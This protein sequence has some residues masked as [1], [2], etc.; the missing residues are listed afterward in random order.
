MGKVRQGDQKARPHARLGDLAGQFGAY[1]AF[2]LGVQ[3]FQAQQAGVM[4]RYGGPF[5]VNF[6][7]Q[8]FGQQVG[9]LCLALAFLLA[10]VG[11]CLG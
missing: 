2:C 9:G 3:L 6:G 11:L 4:T 5:P 7:G 10:L 8:A 1:L